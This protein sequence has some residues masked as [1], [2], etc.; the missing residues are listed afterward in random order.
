M[1]VGRPLNRKLASMDAIH[2]SQRGTCGSFHAQE[3]QLFW[4]C[5][6]L[7]SFHGNEWGVQLISPPPDDFN[8]DIVHNGTLSEKIACVL[9]GK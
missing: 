1:Q 9:L 8:T 5:A 2:A 3:V 4:L 7:G 6:P